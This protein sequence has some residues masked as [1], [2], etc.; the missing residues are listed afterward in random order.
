MSDST[1]NRRSAALRSAKPQGMAT[2]QKI[3]NMFG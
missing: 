1:L 2:C 3:S